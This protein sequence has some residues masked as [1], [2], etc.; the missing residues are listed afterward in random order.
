MT[1]S[2]AVRRG[3]PKPP[4]VTQPRAEPSATWKAIKHNRNVFQIKVPL[5]EHQTAWEFWCLLTADR[6]W[7]SPDSDRTLQKFHL[8]QAKERGAAV[9]DL[10]DL[11]DAMAGRTD[12]R[13]SKGGL[14]AELKVD[15]YIDELGYR[16]ADFFAPYAKNFVMIATG[17]HESAVNKF[18]EVNLIERLVTLLNAK[19]GST[20][21]NGGFS[22]FVVFSFEAHRNGRTRSTDV[23]LHYDHGYGGGG[24]VTRDMIQASRRAAYLPDPD[25]VCSGHVH[26]S[27]TVPIARKRL[28]R[29]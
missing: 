27:L 6:H 18:L 2:T 14:R 15:H 7:D 9:L 16:A 20:I 3:S 26:E 23:V 28:G 4:S 29:F 25:I 24:Q 5:Q 13:G 10:G 19:T 22:G 12:R 8:D 21:H 17:N 1:K 11:Y